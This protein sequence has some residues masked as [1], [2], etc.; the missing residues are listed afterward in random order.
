V[1]P[2]AYTVQLG[3]LAGGSVTPV[4]KPQTVTV[5]PLQASNR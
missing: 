2:G 1:K 4:G 5:V 3:K